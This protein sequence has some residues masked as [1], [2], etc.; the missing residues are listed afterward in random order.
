M[1][2]KTCYHQTSRK[3]LMEIA[4][5]G[6][7]API[8]KPQFPMNTKKR[9]KKKKVLLYVLKQAK[10]RGWWLNLNHSRLKLTDQCKSLPSA[11][12]GAPKRFQVLP[13]PICQSCSSELLPVLSCQGSSLEGIPSTSRDRCH[14]SHPFPV[15]QAG[16]QPW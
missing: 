12:T 3:V 7:H 15:A 9:K 1:V 11:H 13:P 6:A 16:C 2:S 10:R 8:G 4:G 5:F 14:Q